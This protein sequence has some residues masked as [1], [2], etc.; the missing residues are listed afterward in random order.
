[1]RARRSAGIMA[2]LLMHIDLIRV[3]GR[4]DD[5]SVSFLPH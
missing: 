5:E 3:I 2:M 1:V 4:T